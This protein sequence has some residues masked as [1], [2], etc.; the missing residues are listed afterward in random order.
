MPLTLVTRSNFSTSRICISVIWRRRLVCARRLQGSV[1]VAVSRRIQRHQQT[2]LLSGGS[3]KRI[4]SRL[5]RS[6][7]AMRM[8]RYSIGDP[9]SSDL[10]ERWMEKVFTDRKHLLAR[11]STWPVRVHW[12]RCYEGS[13]RVHSVTKLY[14][15]LIHLAQ[16]RVAY[17]WYFRQGIGMSVL[18]STNR[19]HSSSGI[20][21]V[22][23]LGS[24]NV[25][26]FTSAMYCCIAEGTDSAWL[27]YFLQN[28][29]TLS[30]VPSMSD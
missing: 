17:S 29:G 16:V 22:F 10:D 15:L 26:S 12:K 27:A 6:R 25:R 8:R 4:K 24:G 1:E 21:Y 20:S 9:R 28:R 11:T 2:S 23:L 18:I 3:V 5:W 19:R 13:S 30:V 7:Q 14:L